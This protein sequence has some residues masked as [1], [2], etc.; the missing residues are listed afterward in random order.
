MNE[1]M[2]YEK[3]FKALREGKKIRHKV[4]HDDVFYT[5]DGKKITNQLNEDITFVFL[6]NLLNSCQKDI[7]GFYIYEEPKPYDMTYREALMYMLEKPGV[8]QVSNNSHPSYIY[9]VS[10]KET[11]EINGESVHACCTSTYVWSTERAAEWRKE[12]DLEQ[13]DTDVA[14]KKYKKGD[15]LL[16]SA[17]VFKALLS[18]EK[19]AKCIWRKDE[20]K[21][22]HFL[23]IKDGRVWFETGYALTSGFD[24]WWDFGCDDGEWWEIA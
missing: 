22:N 23:I 12:P 7:D 13:S 21:S 11:L 5:Y 24:G 17:E 10:N 3:L 2:T 15:K 8:H 4:N 6:N 9:R 18:G 14:T 20:K 1:K 19:V 16:I